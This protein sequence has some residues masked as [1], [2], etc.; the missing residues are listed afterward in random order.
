MTHD[1]QSLIDRSRALDEA[2]TKL[3]QRKHGEILAQIIMSPSGPP[4]PYPGPKGP[5][6]RPGWTSE[7]EYTL[8]KTS[9]ETAIKQIELLSTHLGDVTDAA[10]KV[11]VNE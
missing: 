5:K 3:A 6:D 8:V 9:I 11:G 7:A 10:V 1:L 4:R 2:L